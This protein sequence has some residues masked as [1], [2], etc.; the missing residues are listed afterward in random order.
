MNWDIGSGPN[1]NF[2][3]GR[4]EYESK[5]A[6]AEGASRN[7]KIAQL[8]VKSLTGMAKVAASG[9][10]GDTLTNSAIKAVHLKDLQQVPGPM[11]LAKISSLA[12]QILA[13]PGGPSEASTYQP[14]HAQKENAPSAENAKFLGPQAFGNRSTEKFSFKNAS[15]D[16]LTHLRQD[17]SVDQFHSREAL[18]Q[19]IERNQNHLGEIEERGSLPAAQHEVSLAE[20]Q[21]VQLQAMLNVMK[22]S[23]IDPG[24]TEK[25]A[26][27]FYFTKALDAAMLVQRLSQKE[28][29]RNVT[30]VANT[31][32]LPPHQSSSESLNLLRRD[33][34]IDQ[35][36]SGSALNT[37]IQ[38][39]RERLAKIEQRG[40]LHA[41]QHEMS[42]AESQRVQLQAMLNVM[43]QSGVDPGATEKNAYKY[44][45]TKAAD[46]TLLVQQLNQPPPSHEDV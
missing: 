28:P 41:A 19:L 25:N 4:Q 44:Y 33:L 36:Y 1:R 34:H 23:G 40:D 15:A 26:Y 20:S 29:L 12:A 43:K 38:I 24:A 5:P 27:K 13:P 22:Q 9:N 45:Y 21:R 31:S 16:I 39:H 2:D 42:L 3:I 32:S 46:A 17:L 6:D 30:N 11:P 8:G 37:L 18:E 7:R 10:S 35:F 14:L